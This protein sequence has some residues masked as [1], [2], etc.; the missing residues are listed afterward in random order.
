MT[1]RTR[2]ALLT[3]TVLGGCFTWA[4]VVVGLSF[5]MVDRGAREWW[6]I[7]PFGALILLAAVLALRRPPP[8]PLPGAASIPQARIAKADSGPDA[9]VPDPDS[10]PSACFPDA[11]P[12]SSTPAAGAVPLPSGH[13]A[14]SAP[15]AG[16]RA[17]DAGPGARMDDA[18]LA[19]D[20]VMGPAELLS[21]RER[22]VLDQLAAGRSNREIAEAL[23]V[24][25]GT[26]K[27]HLSHIFRKLD[28]GSR[29]EAVAH[30]REA[31]L[32]DPAPRP[33]GPPRD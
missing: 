7:P 6:V 8:P 2:R 19:T 27:A 26:V 23:F 30:A 12:V 17:A 5:A 32:L 20:T 3:A 29:L 1:D 33:A 15:L 31:G 28:A 4:M 14:D 11:A 25:P 10:D 18:G 16:A 9:R 13:A 22:E 24:A 21:P